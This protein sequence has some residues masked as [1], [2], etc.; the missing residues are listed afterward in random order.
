MKHAFSCL[1]RREQFRRS[2]PVNPKLNPVILSKKMKIPNR[3]DNCCFSTWITGP[4]RAILSCRQQAGFVGKWR[5]LALAGSCRNFYPATNFK[6]GL[7][8]ARRIPLTRGKFAIVEPK[9]YYK[10]TQFRWYAEKHGKTFYAARVQ[11]GKTIKMHRYIMKAPSHLL[12]DHIDH[13]GL[14]N[15]R[16]NLRLCTVSQNTCNRF[17]LEGSTSKYKGVH[18][19]KKLKKWVVAIKLKGIYKYIG[20][21][22]NEI[23]AAKAY[24]RKA[25]QLHGEFGC[26]NFPNE[27]KEPR[28]TRIYT[29]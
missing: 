25:S 8:K 24:D 3:C 28:I 12:V 2:S 15:C 26:L 14:N 23:D 13:N 10:L 9:D 22:G 18:W 5:F 27:K 29:K 21:F 17:S 6:L 1:V 19:D 16:S 11:S 20:C 7:Q 4:G